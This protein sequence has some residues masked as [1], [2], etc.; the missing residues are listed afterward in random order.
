MEETVVKVTKTEKY[1]MLDAILAAAEQSGIAIDDAAI[2]YEMLHEFIAN[3]QRMLAARTDK[4][5]ERN[6]KKR[7][8]GDKLR[9][10]VYNALSETDFMTINEIVAA[11]G[12][13]DVSN[14]MVINRLK[15]L[16]ED[17]KAEKDSVAVENSE[18]KSKKRSAY[19]KLA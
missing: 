14:A 19:R 4:A 12:D 17:G 16:V 10:V 7:A 1:A 6:A 13:E 2:T 9:E 11:I 15:Y 8:E 3:E 5:K 18:G